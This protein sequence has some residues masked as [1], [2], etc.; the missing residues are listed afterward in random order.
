MN[1]VV[2]FFRRVLRGC[3]IGL[4]AIGATVCAQSVQ[5]LVDRGDR[6]TDPVR[7]EQWYTQALHLNPQAEQAWLARSIVRAKQQHYQEALEDVSGAIGLVDTIPEFY[8]QRG[9]IL[10]QLSEYDA[11]SADLR[12]AIRLSPR[13]ARFYSGLSYCRLKQN[14]L[15][16]AIRL[17]E[18]SIQLAPGSPYPYRNRGRARLYQGRIGDA[19]FDFEHSLMLGHGEPY[20]VLTD[21]GEAAEKQ[22]KLEKALQYYRQALQQKPD[23]AEAIIRQQKLGSTSVAT[24]PAPA[25]SVSRSTFTGKR[26]ALLIGNAVYPYIEPSLDNQ[27]LEDVRAMDTRLR[28]LGFTTTRKD[29]IEGD[30]LRRSMDAFYRQ[31]EQADV[32]VFYFAGHGLQYE[33]AN[34]LLPTDI[35]LYP[36]DTAQYVS[37]LTQQAL[38][39]T[40]VI[41]RLQKVNPRYCLIMLDAC[42]EDP[43][44]GKRPK[45]AQVSTRFKPDPFVPIVVENFIRNCCV[46][47]ATTPGSRAWNGPNRNG[48]YTEALMKFLKRGTLLEQML[49]QVRSDVMDTARKAGKDQRPE[50]LNQVSDD[51]VF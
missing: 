35:E 32:V 39:V 23:Y 21:L 29:N 47:Q 5:D 24:P 34:Y 30:S 15:A 19:V 50:S 49:K 6:E 8:G 48:C 25:G 1:G 38:L 3:T 22:H 28:D 18:R 2:R 13:D 11:A 10:I 20:R 26:V 37:K 33:G 4:S 17:A 46:A 9:Y 16:E 43:L 51:L 7:A 40:T 27:P 36:N 45:S 31:A 14:H 42:R 44:G 41:E 12:K